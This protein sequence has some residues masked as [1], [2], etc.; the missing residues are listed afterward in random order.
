MHINYFKSLHVT[1]NDF[2]NFFQGK[3]NLLKQRNT[4][5]IKMPYLLV[6][7]IDF[8]TT[9]S[10]CAFSF[11][12]EFMRDP[13]KSFVKNWIDPNSSMMYCKT[14]TCILFNKEKEFGEFGFAA[15][16]KFL[17]LILENDHQNWYFFRRFKMAL[18]EL[19][20]IIFMRL[21]PVAYMFLKLKTLSF[22]AKIIC[23]IYLFVY[24]FIILKSEDQEIL[25]EDENGNT[26]PALTVFSAS[27][28]YLKQSLLD[29]VN[30][31]VIISMGDIKW[32]ITVPAIWS[33]P[34]KTFMRR[35]AIQVFD[36]IT[37]LFITF[38][39]ESFVNV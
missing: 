39:N 22:Y 23:V 10:G 3:I 12:D 30:D 25:I 28:R 15:E 2:H 13:T 1:C 14:S 34:A 31:G 36:F 17:D 26:M 20:V 37:N 11:N 9:Y 27:L 33:D 35:A 5:K 38:F 18:Y 21:C 6:A 24:L 29:D 4:F 7:A 19:Q 16:A 8:G 32:V